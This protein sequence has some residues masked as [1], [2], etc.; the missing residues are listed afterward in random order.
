[1]LLATHLCGVFEDWTYTLFREEQALTR[2]GNVRLYEL[3]S[4]VRCTW[5][6]R[7]GELLAGGFGFDATKNTQVSS[8]LF[9]G[10]YFAATGD[11]PDRQAF[12]KGVI[13]KLGEEQELIEWTSEALRANQLQNFSAKLG[14]IVTLILA[15][16]LVVM[17]FIFNF[18]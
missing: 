18:R 7:L 1:M 6:A 11:S 5:K 3:L 17:Y 15:V 14:M 8:N 2:P 13:E 4:K 12:V 9:S 10:C 16:S